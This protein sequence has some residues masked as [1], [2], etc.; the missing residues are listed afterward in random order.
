M[1]GVTSPSGW[2]PYISPGLLGLVSHDQLGKTVT[3]T[4]Q[5]L[6]LNL[7]EGVVCNLR[8]GCLPDITAQGAT[9]YLLDLDLYRQTGREFNVLGI[10]QAGEMFNTLAL[11]LFEASVT[12]AL[13]KELE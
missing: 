5:Q 11:Q 13:L 4:Q 12:P 6:T 2:R 8:H 10:E 9:V 1:P 3:M 7:G